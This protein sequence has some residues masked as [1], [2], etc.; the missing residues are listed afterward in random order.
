MPYVSDPRLLN[1]FINF[2]VTIF[3]IRKNDLKFGLQIFTDIN[4]EKALDFW[5]RE[6]KVSR[7]QFQKPVVT[8]SGSIGTYRRK[9]KN[10]V[11]TLYYNN[12]KARD[13]LMSLL[14]M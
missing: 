8:L 1:E 14:P 12:K 11:V 5:C 3:K 13:I 9:S 6:L 7:T 2:L 10:G 4:P